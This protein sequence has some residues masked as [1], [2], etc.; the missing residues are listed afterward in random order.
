MLYYNNTQACD[1]D[2]YVD[3]SLKVCPSQH[4]LVL[5][6]FRKFLVSGKLP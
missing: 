6:L 4:F 3:Q 5:L 1:Y 2:G